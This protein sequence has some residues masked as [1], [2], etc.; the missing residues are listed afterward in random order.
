MSRPRL[1]RTEADTPCSTSQVQKRCTASSVGRRY[2]ASGISLN[3]SRLTLQRRPCSSLTRRLASARLSL[4]SRNSTYSK[5]MRWR[6]A[7]GKSRHAREGKTYDIELVAGD[8]VLVVDA[9]RFQA[10]MRISGQEGF[11]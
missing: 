11:A 6:T 4:T 10:S 8:M 5:V 3:G 1:W 7:R 2:G 9:W